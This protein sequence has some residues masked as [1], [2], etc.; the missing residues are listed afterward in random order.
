VETPTSPFSFSACFFCVLFFLCVCFS[1]QIGSVV[2]LI[3]FRVSF[4]QTA[5]AAVAAVKV[6]KMK[7]RVETAQRL[8]PPGPALHTHRHGQQI[9]PPII[10]IIFFLAVI[11]L[12]G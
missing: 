1:V 4:C 3:L 6:H 9:V 8:A 2:P 5:V 7:K 12:F 11:F 10:I